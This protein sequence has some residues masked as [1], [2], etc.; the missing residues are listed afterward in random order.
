[1]SKPAIEE[2]VMTIPWFELNHYMFPEAGV[3]RD[4][5]FF[6]RIA[7]CGF[8]MWPR[9]S[10]V[11][12][13]EQCK[14]VATYCLTYLGDGPD[15][16]Y[17]AYQRGP[18]GDGEDRLES[19]WSIGIGGHVER[20]DLNLDAAARREFI[21]EASELL[22]FGANIAVWEPIGVINDD[23]NPV[24]RVHLGALFDVPLATEATRGDIEESLAASALRNARLVTAA[25]LAE[26]RGKLEPWSQLVLRDVI[27]GGWLDG[28]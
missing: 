10:L 1:M 16:L 8:V 15:R 19:L 28:R 22:D 2:R 25:E 21:E 26:M 20:A 4:P 24:G 9:R 17:V 14:H 7:D 12:A 13:N 6:D 23:T 27:E 18:K 5:G 3:L 11:E